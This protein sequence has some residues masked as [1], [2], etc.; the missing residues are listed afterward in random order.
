MD[1]KITMK[2][3]NLYAY[4]VH[5]DKEYP[6][7][8][9]VGQEHDDLWHIY[10]DNHNER[11]RLCDSRQSNGSLITTNNSDATCEKCQEVKDNM[12]KSLAEAWR[13]FFPDHVNDIIAEEGAKASIRSMFGHH[14]TYK[15][16]L[17]TDS[18]GNISIENAIEKVQLIDTGEKIMGNPVYRAS[19]ISSLDEEESLLSN[20][21]LTGLINS[22]FFDNEEKND[23]N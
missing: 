7:K 8:M 5:E 15:Q 23:D 9:I 13:A 4:T 3:N 19:T 17:V 2:N 14:M 6:V 1:I 11:K 21:V 16:Y 18:D 12:E 10:I 20:D 22:N